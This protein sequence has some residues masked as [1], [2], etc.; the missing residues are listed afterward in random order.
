M[1]FRLSGPSSIV[2]RENVVNLLDGISR[3]FISTREYECRYSV[4]HVP[5]TIDSFIDSSVIRALITS[6]IDFSETDALLRKLPSKKSAIEAYLANGNNLVD[7]VGIDYEKSRI[8]STRILN[9]SALK[10]LFSGQFLPPAKVTYCISSQCG[11]SNWSKF[12]TEFIEYRNQ[13]LR[14]CQNRINAAIPNAVFGAM[15][16]LNK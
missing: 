6:H 2:S 7:C 3:C 5:W 15:A 4:E 11:N 13:Q 10:D 16:N 9:E 1:A 14:E 8:I 12:H